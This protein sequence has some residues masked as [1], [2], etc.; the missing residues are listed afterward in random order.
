MGVKFNLVNLQIIG[1]T[2][3]IA[4]RVPYIN[5]VKLKECQSL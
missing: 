3:Y 5:Y 1:I 4:N 2:R